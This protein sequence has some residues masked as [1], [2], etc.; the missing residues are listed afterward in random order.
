LCLIPVF[1][2]LTSSD[3][4]LV[5][6]ALFYEISFISCNNLMTSTWL[7][8]ILFSSFSNYCCILINLL[9][10]S[11]HLSSNLFSILITTPSVSNLL[12]SIFL[13]SSLRDKNSFWEYSLLRFSTFSVSSFNP[14]I[15]SNA[16][17]AN[18]PNAC[19][20]DLRSLFNCSISYFDFSSRLA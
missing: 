7:S 19:L 11:K 9:F 8:P 16:T 3:K 2:K 13:R 15:S 20:S 18:V 5:C 6:F 14:S 17:S 1:I 12:E 10:N 4:S